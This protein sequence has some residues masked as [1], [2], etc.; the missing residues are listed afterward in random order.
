MEHLLK[1][2]VLFKLKDKKEIP[3]SVDILLSMRGK[4][5]EILDMEVGTDI[6]DS[7]RSYDIALV[8]T[9]ADSA[10]LDRY[11]N[12]P[13]HCAVVKKHMHAVREKSV[14]VDYII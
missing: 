13:Y 9:L 5:S 10:A 14:S 1:H 8:V 12:D 2:I 4:V 6:L 11:Q 7:D 3:A